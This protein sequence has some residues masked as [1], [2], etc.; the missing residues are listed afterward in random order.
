MCRG[1]HLRTCSLLT[2]IS[3]LG[4]LDAVWCDGNDDRRLTHGEGL[5]GTHPCG[6]P[7]RRRR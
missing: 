6:P 4:S 7:A 5:R 2:S 1:L 3:V